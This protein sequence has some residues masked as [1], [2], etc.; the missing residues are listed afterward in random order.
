MHSGAI[1]RI[2][3]VDEGTAH[4][5]NLP[6]EQRRGISVKATCVSLTWKDTAINL[7]DTPG[8]V[9]FSAEVERS[10]W[11][12]DA[13]VVVVCAV[14][15]VQPHTET[16]FHALKIEGL[17]KVESLNVLSGRFI[18]LEYTLQNGE[19]VKFLDDSSTYLGNQLACEFGGD[20]CFGIAANMDFILIC[21]YE[22]DAANPELVIYKKR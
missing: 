4:T 15:G 16:L 13:A 1:R 3:S 7:I 17:P 11:A 2:G 5:D 19:N 9:D 10:L 21:T 20:R 18:N 6:V 8:H 22:A 14:E 12:L